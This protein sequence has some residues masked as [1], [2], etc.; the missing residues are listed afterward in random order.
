MVFNLV[1][2]GENGEIVVVIGVVGF[3]GIKIVELLNMCG[4]NI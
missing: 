1:F 4:M 3:L 2:F